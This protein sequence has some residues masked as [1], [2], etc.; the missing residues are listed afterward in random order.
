MNRR[1]LLTTSLGATLAAGLAG[2]ATPALAT[3]SKASPH[4]LVVDAVQMPAWVNR[5]GRRQPLSPGD[6]VTTAEEVE[7][8]ASAGLVMRLP[9]GSLIRLGEKTRLGIQRLEARP[10][11]GFTAV[12]SELKL[13]DGFFRFA[14]SAVAKAVGQREIDV[15]LRT[16][17]VGIR[18]TDFWS[19]TDDKHD[20]TCLFEGRVDLATRDQGA[21][22]LEKP[23]AFWARFFDRPV[24]PVGVATPDELAKFLKSTEIQPGQG[25]AV[26]GGRWRVVAAALADEKAAAALAVRL[27]A[28]GYPAVTRAK[29]LAGKPAHEVRING[30]A[31]R[32]DAEAVLAKIKP[33]EGVSGRVALSA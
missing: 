26:P 27:R 10:E 6:T 24:Q 2:A 4:V 12:R 16:A 5:D 33:L 29:T 23:T 7:T 1:N 31:T 13:F 25:V 18:G 20:A 14:T 28:E 15:N 11:E 17:T 3:K 32:A 19:M 22:T 8:A 9:E 30:L 21:L